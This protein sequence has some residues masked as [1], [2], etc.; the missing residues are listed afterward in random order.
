M[1]SDSFIKE[2]AINLYQ[3]DIFKDVKETT[4]FQEYEFIYNDD[5]I[6]K[7]G[8]IDLLIEHPSHIDIVDYKLSDVTDE[9]YLLQLNGYKDYVQKKTNKPIHLYLYS[10]LEKKLLEI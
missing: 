3:Q 4:I 5:N 1:I 6:E 10:I 8:V 9:N 2:L 7:H